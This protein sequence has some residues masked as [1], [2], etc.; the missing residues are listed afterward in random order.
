MSKSQSCENSNPYEFLKNLVAEVAKLKEAHTLTR[1]GLAN[2][3][4]TCPKWH[5]AVTAVPIF[6]F[7]LPDQCLCIVK[8][9][10]ICTYVCMTLYRLF[11]NYRCYQITLQWNIFTQIGA[12]QSV[13]WILSLGRRPGGVTGRIRDVGQNVLQSYYKQEAAAAAQLLPRVLPYHIP[14]AG[15]Y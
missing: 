8:N 14:R 1:P 13:D 4:H 5:V 15:L 12:V 6:V 11:M 7:L 9:M 10:C 3:R 2:L